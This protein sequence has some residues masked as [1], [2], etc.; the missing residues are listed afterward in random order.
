MSSQTVLEFEIQTYL[1]T[2][3][4]NFLFINAETKAQRE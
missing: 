4:F 2:K 1:I 3:L